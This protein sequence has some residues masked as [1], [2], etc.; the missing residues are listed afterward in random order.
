[1]AFLGIRHMGHLMLTVNQLALVILALAAI[2]MGLS[3]A[4][5]WRDEE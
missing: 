2:G 1:V 5:I 3:L 4:G